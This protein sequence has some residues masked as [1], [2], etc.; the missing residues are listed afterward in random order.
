[1]QDAVKNRTNRHCIRDEEKT[2]RVREK[3]NSIRI[4]GVS[5]LVMKVKVRADLHSFGS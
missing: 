4:D 1:M 3:L 2:N 5:R